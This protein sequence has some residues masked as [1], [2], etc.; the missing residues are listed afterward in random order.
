MIH[1]KMRES[2][3]ELGGGGAVGARPLHLIDMRFF[4]PI[5]YQNAEK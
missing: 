4:H 3:E 1:L 5:L 2:V